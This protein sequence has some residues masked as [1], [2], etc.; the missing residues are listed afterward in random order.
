MDTAY[1]RAKNIGVMLVIFAVFALS[2]ML[3]KIAML[4]VV[5]L[6]LSSMTRV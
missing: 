5:G 6:L 3:L 1:A 4:P 2:P